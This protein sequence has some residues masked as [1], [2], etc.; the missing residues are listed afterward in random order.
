MTDIPIHIRK[1]TPDD[2]SDVQSCARAAYSMY[3][4]RMEQEPA[5][6]NADFADQIAQ[7]RVHVVLYEE[8]FA[9]Y[10]VFYPVDDHVHLENVAVLPT[11][12][13]KE[14]GR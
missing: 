5:P 3:T 8:Q 11:Q 14:I 10:V 6:M 7:G 9:G 13:G 4:N 2:L 12:S 1:A